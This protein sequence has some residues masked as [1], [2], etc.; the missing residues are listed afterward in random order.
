MADKT[1]LPG[2]MKVT[3]TVSGLGWRLF[4]RG[5]SYFTECCA[6]ALRH[7][8]MN[9]VAAHIILCIMWSFGIANIPFFSSGKIIKF[10]SSDNCVEYD[11]KNSDTCSSPPCIHDARRV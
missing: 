11:R 9:I 6:C 1:I 3:E 10:A 5:I 7:R 4:G 2:T 8:A